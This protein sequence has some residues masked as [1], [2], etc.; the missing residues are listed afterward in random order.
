VSCVSFARKSW[1]IEGKKLPQ[2]IA[3]S[4][5]TLPLSDESSRSRLSPLLVSLTLPQATA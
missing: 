4:S 2:T 5:V 3:S 1:P